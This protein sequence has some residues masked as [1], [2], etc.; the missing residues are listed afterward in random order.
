MCAWSPE[1]AGELLGCWILGSEFTIT[2]DVGAVAV[3]ADWRDI[4]A[5]ICPAEGGCTRGSPGL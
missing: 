4:C 2:Q 5:S 1:T 3:M